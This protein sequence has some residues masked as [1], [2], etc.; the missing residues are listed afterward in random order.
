MGNIAGDS[1]RCRDFVL[2][3]NAMPPLLEQLNYDQAK[4]GMLRNATW[5]LSNFCRGKPAPNFAITKQALPTL[6]RL[7]H[8][9]DEEV[10]TDSCWALSYLSDGDNDRIDR[11]IEANVC[12]RLVELLMHPSPSVLV[13]ALRTAGNIVT[14][15]DMQTQCII[16]CGAL[17]CLM[18]LLVTN[19]KKSI[20]KETCWT[21]SNITAGT[22]VC[23]CLFSLRSKA[24]IM[25]LS[26]A[27]I[28]A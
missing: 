25:V 13:P 3:H 20:K 26:P 28:P 2:G 23:A 21:I 7:I 14:G 5:T 10:L 4:M 24:S 27:S 16:N 22:K 8:H 17:N 9:G 1:P 11:V 12:R 15:N 6:A 18:N 19:Q